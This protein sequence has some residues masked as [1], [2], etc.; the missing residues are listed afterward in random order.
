MKNTMR[1]PFTDEPNTACI[2]C[3]HVLYE[4]KSILYVSHDE[5]DGCWQFMCGGEH[6]SPDDAGVIA[7]SEIY[8]LD[9]SVSGIADMPCGCE[10]ERESE[11]SAWKII[12][13]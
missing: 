3:K 1:Y 5:E 11:T 10:A 9:N 7:L 8:E 4:K 13:Q 2:V 12:K 6:E